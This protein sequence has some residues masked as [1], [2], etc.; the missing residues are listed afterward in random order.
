MTRALVEEI[1]AL[2]Q[3]AEGKL[4]AAHKEA[5]H[6]IA[7]AREQAHT[8]VEQAK[9]GLD[10]EREVT[11][12]EHAAALQKETK[13]QAANADTQVA[14]LRKKVSPRIEKAAQFAIDEFLSSGSQ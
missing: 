12:R 4:A 5:E 3:T 2:E 11:M 10:A 7:K 1:I 8:I 13:E 9:A 6:V 14:A